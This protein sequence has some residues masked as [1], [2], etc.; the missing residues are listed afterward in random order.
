[1][2]AQ[3]QSV[4]RVRIAGRIVVNIRHSAYDVP[5]IEQLKSAPN[6]IRSLSSGG[7]SPT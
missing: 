6:S 4:T 7:G 2:S 1:M 3:I 5:Q